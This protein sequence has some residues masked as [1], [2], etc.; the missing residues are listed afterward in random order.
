MK[1]AIQKFTAEETEL[2]EKLKA[3]IQSLPDGPDG[4]T[5]LGSNCCSVPIS[6]VREHGFNWSPRYWLAAETKTALIALVDEC[7]SLNSISKNIERIIKTGKVG[8]GKQYAVP[9]NIIEAL[10]RA[11]EG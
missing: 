6:L 7:Q 1:T 8:C 9:P 2:R 3:L 5:M 11:W 10:K 4:V